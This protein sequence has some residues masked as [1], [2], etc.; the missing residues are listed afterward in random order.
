MW[1]VPDVSK[2][3]RLIETSLTTHLTTQITI[4]EDLKHRMLSSYGMFQNYLQELRKPTEQL[5]LKG[6]AFEIS[7]ARKRNPKRFTEKLSC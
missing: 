2:A 7:I 3:P 4:P 6:R 1:V 5:S